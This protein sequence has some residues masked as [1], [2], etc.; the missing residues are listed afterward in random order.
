MFRYSI[1]KLSYFPRD[2]FIDKSE[3][4]GLSKATLSEENNLVSVIATLKMG[5][6]VETICKR[7]Y[8]SFSLRVV[9]LFN[10]KRWSYKLD[11]PFRRQAGSDGR[12]YPVALWESQFLCSLKDSIELRPCVFMS[13]VSPK[14][15]ME[16]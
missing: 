2:D 8:E 6:A 7:E 15:L 9:N 3:T 12:C 14:A 1:I 10:W 5:K 4:A 13:F 16:R 11:V